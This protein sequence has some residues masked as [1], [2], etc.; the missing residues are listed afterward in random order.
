MGDEDVASHVG[1]E[2]RGAGNVSL[3]IRPAKLWF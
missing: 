2:K 3:L 1:A